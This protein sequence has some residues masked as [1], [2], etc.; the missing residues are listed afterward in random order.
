[1]LKRN[2]DLNISK[3]E[4]QDKVPVY[5]ILLNLKSLHEVPPLCSFTGKLY[6][7]LTSQFKFSGLL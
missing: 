5:I 4:P 1:M 6:S 3:Y 2:T 7:A